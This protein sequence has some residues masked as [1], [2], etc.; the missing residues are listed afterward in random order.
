MTAEVQAQTVLSPGIVVATRRL[1]QSK[2]GLV[3][4]P[5]DFLRALGYYRRV[6]LRVMEA[7][8]RERKYD[9][10][11]DA[12]RRLR[13][14]DEIMRARISKILGL[15]VLP[16]EVQNGIKELLPEEHKLLADLEALLASY[17]SSILEEGA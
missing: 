12:R 15:L 9:T 11:E 16:P 5:A 6:T 7:A 13:D 14:A 1:E 10:V 8:L 4:Q 17:S 2:R 3:A